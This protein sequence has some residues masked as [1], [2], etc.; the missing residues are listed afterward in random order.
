MK[1]NKEW[2]LA[3]ELIHIPGFPTTPQGVNKRARLENW[4]KRAVAVPGARGRSFEYHIDNFSTE[5]QAVL[6]Q[7]QSLSNGSELTLKEQEWLTLFRSLSESEQAF[8]LYTL[9]RKGIEWLV[10]QSELY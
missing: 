7:S 2:F 10:Q 8:M 1:I 6:N 3:K 9:R 5:I 4:K